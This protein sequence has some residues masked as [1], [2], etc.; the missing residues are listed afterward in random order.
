MKAVPV[1]AAVEVDG[2]FRLK[3]E[4]AKLQWNMADTAALE[5]ALTLRGQRL[6][7][8]GL[9]AV[10]IA[11]VGTPVEVRTAPQLLR[12]DHAVLKMLGEPPYQRETSF[13]IEAVR[14]RKY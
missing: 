12:E 8:E 5:A 9:D 10:K 14:M 4:G 6:E 11:V 3:R 13:L 2:Q 1:T 7:I